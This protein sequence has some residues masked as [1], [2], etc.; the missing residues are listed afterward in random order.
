MHIHLYILG[1][2]LS[3]DTYVYPNTTVDPGPDEV[4]EGRRPSPFSDTE[5]ETRRV[6]EPNRAHSR[7]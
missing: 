7:P 3:H 4:P 2:Y 6:A 5:K 1:V